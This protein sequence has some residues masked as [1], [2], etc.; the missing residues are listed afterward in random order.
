MKIE[1]DGLLIWF[2]SERRAYLC[3]IHSSQFV[4]FNE[5]IE[6]KILFTPNSDSLWWARERWY[7]ITVKQEHW[8]FSGI[9]GSIEW[10][11]EN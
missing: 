11:G 10:C 9:S 2:I 1:S 7:V 6:M 5:K 4:A 3:A 8:D